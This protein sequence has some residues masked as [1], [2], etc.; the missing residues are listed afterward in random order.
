LQALQSQQT[1]WHL[2]ARIRVY[3]TAPISS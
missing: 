3:T 2:T 1:P